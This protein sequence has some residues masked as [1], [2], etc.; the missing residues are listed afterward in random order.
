MKKLSL[1]V[2]S[3]VAL[4]AAGSTAKE[5]PLGEAPAAPRAQA[6]DT[7]R[8]SEAA[9]A[10]VKKKARTN[11]RGLEAPFKEKIPGGIRPVGKKKKTFER[12]TSTR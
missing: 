11:P 4:F 9:R 5:A 2:G 1:L 6:P 12:G 7:L 8:L 10:Q 3:L